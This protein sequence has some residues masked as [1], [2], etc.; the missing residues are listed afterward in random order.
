[1]SFVNKSKGH[2]IVMVIMMQEITC[3]QGLTGLVF[4]YVHGSKWHNPEQVVDTNVSLAS[5]TQ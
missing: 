4:Q 1:M 3:N 2:N 5:W